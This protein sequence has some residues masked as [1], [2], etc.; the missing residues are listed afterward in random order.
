MDD[1]TEKNM[2]F[3]TSTGAFVKSTGDTFNAINAVKSLKFLDDH[4]NTATPAMATLQLQK[5]Y[6][7]LLGAGTPAPESL[8]AECLQVGIKDNDVDTAAAIRHLN[9][10]F[11]ADVEAIQ[12]RVLNSKLDDQNKIFSGSK[13]LQRSVN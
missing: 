6:N 2:T 9:S 10:R 11:R 13:I 1:Q 5:H 3:V 8:I 7:D 12:S 4:F